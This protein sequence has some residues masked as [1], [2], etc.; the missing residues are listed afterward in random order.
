V[1]VVSASLVLGLA[2]AHGALALLALWLAGQQAL[3]LDPAYWSATEL[4]FWPLGVALA[5]LAAAGPAWRAVRTDVTQLL[6][7]PR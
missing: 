5:L 1:L 2:L 3:P 6:Q 4:W 7:A